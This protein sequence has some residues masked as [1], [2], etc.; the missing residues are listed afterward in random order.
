M[1]SIERVLTTLSH[2]EPDRVPMFLLLTMQGA[3]FHNMTMEEYYQNPKAIAEAQL[4]FHEKYDNDVLYSFHYA[5]IETQ[6]YGG[7]IVIRDD[8]PVNAGDPIIKNFEDIDALKVPDVE[9]NEHLSKVYETIRYLAEAKG[10]EVLIAGV[11]MSPYSA[12]VM[13]MGMENYMKLRIND[14]KRFKKLMEINTE[15]CIR[16]AN[17]MLKNGANAIVYFDPIGSPTMST[18]AEYMETGYPIMKEC[19]EKINGPIAAHF[20]SGIVLPIIDELIDSG[21]VAVGTSSL[22]DHVE[23]K[24]RCKGKLTIVGN[25]NGIEMNRWSTDET[26]QKVKDIINTCKEGGGYIL[27]DNHGEIPIQIDDEIVKTISSTVKTYG[28][29]K[30]KH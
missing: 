21:I 12:P 8:R 6:A 3:K 19:V 14:P 10:G 27:S 25:L 5:S 30:W 17:E 4:H 22:E 9:N 16:Y 7:D 15:F 11:V 13:Q 1:K 28:T 26:K 18:K 2:Q 23:L 20:A 24:K 29:Y